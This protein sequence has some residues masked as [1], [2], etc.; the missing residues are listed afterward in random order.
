[1]L[2]I[3]ICDDEE[4]ICLQV[5]NILKKVSQALL[6]QVKIEVFFTGE[7]LCHFL[8]EEVYF[9]MIFLDIELKM[10]SGIEVGKKIREEMNNESTQIVY[11]SGK[12]SYAMELFEVR[13]LNFLIKPLTYEG[14]EKVFKLTLKL[15]QEGKQVF[16]Y[17]V[18]RVFHK[19][20]V[21]DILYFEGSVKY[22]MKNQN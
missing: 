15:T 10:M 14:V 20:P 5:E 2:H 18:G 12:D 3:A 11:I 16:Q 6:E 17:E 7:E 13:P 1:M 21:K 19:I 8:S 4:T 9:D 22:S